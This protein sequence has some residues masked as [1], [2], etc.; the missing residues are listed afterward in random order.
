MKL[1]DIMKSDVE[2]IPPEC[3][4]ADAARKMK[5]LDVGALPI[6]DGER[7]LGMITDRDITVKGT[8]EG[9]NPDQIEVRDIM[10]SPVIYLFE[11]ENVES[12]VRLMEVKQIRRLI[13]LN[14]DKKLAGIVSLGDLAVKTGN[15]E[16]AGEALEKISEPKGR[17]A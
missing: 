2:V 16:L 15:E 12:A 17:V 11:D 9:L 8:A 5:S 1:R 14:R 13:V 3:N 6:C 10:S 7:L 4:L